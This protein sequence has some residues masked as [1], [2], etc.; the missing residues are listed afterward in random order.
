MKINTKQ[1]LKTLKG[2]ELKNGDIPFTLGEALGNILLSD[3]TGGKMKLY[4]L[5]T[6]FSQD[7]EVELDKADLELVRNAV[8]KTEIYN[9]LVA[10]QIEVILS[11]K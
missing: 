3:K 7:K 11:E 9:A 6:K 4:V 8:S 1:A 5:A 10:G 2:E